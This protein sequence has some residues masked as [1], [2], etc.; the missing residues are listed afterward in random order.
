MTLLL[1]DD[2]AVVH[3]IL[4]ARDAKSIRDFLAELPGITVPESLE[5]ELER[6][7]CDAATASKAVNTF[8]VE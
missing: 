8:V 3:D 1:I 7:R 6:Y 5:E 4:D 2:E